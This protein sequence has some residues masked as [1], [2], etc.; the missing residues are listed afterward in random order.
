MAAH[1]QQAVIAEVA[2]DERDQV[3]LGM[4]V[5][6]LLADL[7]REVVRQSLVEARI[8]LQAQHSCPLHCLGDDWPRPAAELDR[9]EDSPLGS[10]K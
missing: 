4:L 10:R 3:A 2:E 8:G 7:V 9:L 6:E 5:A 1:A